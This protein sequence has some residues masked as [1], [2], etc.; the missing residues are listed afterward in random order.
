MMELL[1]R[2]AG[3][4]GFR[5]DTILNVEMQYDIRV[6]II[7][8]TYEEP[9]SYKWLFFSE[10]TSLVSGLLNGRSF[11]GAEYL[12]Q[13]EVGA[14]EKL[15]KV[16]LGR[17]NCRPALAWLLTKEQLR[18]IEECVGDVPLATISD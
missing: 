2:L 6:S 17:Q 7:A 15:T 12:R 11:R 5:T 16:P 4:T 13:M 1:A 9:D 10:V 8:T 18:G 14:E 3:H